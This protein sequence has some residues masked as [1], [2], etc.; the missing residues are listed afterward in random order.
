M[1][2]HPDAEK[3]WTETVYHDKKGP[4]GSLVEID[5]FC[6]W[7]GLQQALFENTMVIERAGNGPYRAI[8]MRQINPSQVS[9]QNERP[10]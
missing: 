5:D 3:D 2:A 6:L 4:G 9:E 7:Y 10:H 1:V 8:G